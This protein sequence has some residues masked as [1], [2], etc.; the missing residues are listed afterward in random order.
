[1]ITC[2]TDKSIRIWNYIDNTCELVKYFPDE[3]LCVSIHPSGLYILAGFG[4]KLR[5]MNVL[6]D[7]IRVFY[8]FNVR[9]CREVRR[10]GGV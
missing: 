3:P 1:M 8:E 6:I 2:A 9:S 10:A 7:D 5:L 4:D